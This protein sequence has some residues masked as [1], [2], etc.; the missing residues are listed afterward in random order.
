MKTNS[1]NWVNGSYYLVKRAQKL[2]KLFGGSGPF[3]YLTMREIAQEAESNRY[4]NWVGYWESPR[5]AWGCTFRAVRLSRSQPILFLPLT[6]MDIL[7]L[8]VYSQYKTET[9]RVIYIQTA[10]RHSGRVDIC[11]PQF[12][13]LVR[14]LNAPY[15]KA[16]SDVFSNCAAKPL[17][18]SPSVMSMLLN[19]SANH[20]PVEASDGDDWGWSS[21]DMEL[22]ALSQ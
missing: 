4:S 22:R 18:D 11:D 17:D 16:H 3:G 14:A 7:G 9:A 2:S 12:V 5:K 21:T 20:T 10:E 19:S 15:L 1:I 6:Y 8:G 13:K